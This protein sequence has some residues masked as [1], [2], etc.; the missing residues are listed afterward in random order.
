MNH[1][2]STG[3]L[4]RKLII[5]INASLKLVLFTKQLMNIN[6]ESGHPKGLYISTLINL[7]CKTVV[8]APGWY[9]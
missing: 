5:E 1:F 3:K 8:N 6:F 4:D 2:I 7:L 9:L